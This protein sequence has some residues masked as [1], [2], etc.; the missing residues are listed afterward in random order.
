MSDRPKRDQLPGED[1]AYF[2]DS[3]EGERVQVLGVHVTTKARA[4]DTGG[5]F[6]VTVFQGPAGT[7]APPHH[8]TNDAE[9]FFVL[10]G[11][12]RW[13]LGDEERL[14]YP[15]DFGYWPAGL[16]HAFRFEGAYNKM[17]GLNFP[18][19]FEDF[20]TQLGQET[21]A[22]VSVPGEIT[23]P[24]PE[25]FARVIEEHAWVRRPDLKID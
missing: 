25:L 6:G 11:C 7:G 12:V 17:I 18:G 5:L 24:D 3:D 1:R 16:A 2:L 15:G 19:G 22:Y 4:V 10:D 8:H 13:W 14:T 21:D 23:P 9:A 20:F